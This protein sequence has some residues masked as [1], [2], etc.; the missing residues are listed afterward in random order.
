[1]ICEIVTNINLL[2]IWILINLI[3]KELINR[4]SPP[5]IIRF[6]LIFTQKGRSFP[7]VELLLI[8]GSRNITSETFKRIFHF[9]ILKD[10]I[11]N[12]VFQ[13]KNCTQPPAWLTDRGFLVKSA[14]DF[15][16][17]YFIRHNNLPAFCCP[18]F[19]IFFLFLSNYLF[20]TVSF[21]SK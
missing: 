15:A 12:S 19:N 7:N 5:L 14:V 6:T 18:F 3:K 2:L 1:M 21:S 8:L 20:L 16:V 4:L 9:W 13:P 10:V 17:H 11:S